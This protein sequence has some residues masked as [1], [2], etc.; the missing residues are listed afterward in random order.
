MIM[1]E[2]YGG[3]ALR[4]LVGV[5]LVFGII[6]GSI[7]LGAS[8]L[9]VDP[10]KYEGKY[11]LNT[12][13]FTF[14]EK[15]ALYYIQKYAIKESIS[16]ALVMGIIKHE[17]GG[18]FDPNTLGDKRIGYTGKDENMSIGYMQVWWTAAYDAGFRGT[19]KPIE[20]ELKKQYDWFYENCFDIFAKVTPTDEKFF[21]YID[22]ATKGLD[23]D[24]NVKY[25]ITYLRLRHDKIKDDIV[26]SDP[27]K[28]TISAYNAY[29]PTKRNEGTYVTPVLNN[30]IAYKGKYYSGVESGWPAEKPNEPRHPWEG[31]LDFEKGTDRAVISSTIQGL[32]FTTTLGLNWLYGDKHKYN[33]YPYGSKSYEA[34][35][36]FFA[37]LG[38]S[39]DQGII[40]FTKGTANYLS[41]LTSTS[42]GVKIDAYD[43]DNN[44]LVTSG[45]SGSNIN[46]RT[47]TRL[48]VESP[49]MAYATIHDTGNYWL[50]DDLTTD[51]LG[52]PSSHYGAAALAKSVVGAPYLGDG[53]TWGGKGWDPAKK[54]VSSTEIKD[55]YNYYDN[56][57][58]YKK[59]RW[60]QGLD[61]SGLV[62]WSYNKA[63]GATTYQYSNSED[64]LN[65]V[66]W[67]GA[68]KQY[69]YNFDI[70]VN[71]KEDLL[72]GDVLFFGDAATQSMYHVAMYVG[73]YPYTGTINGIP[74]DG[75]Y[76]VVNA[77]SPGLG[78]VPDKVE[79]LKSDPDF[80][81]YRRLSEPKVSMV[82][83]SHSPVNLIITDPDGIM[84]N[85]EIF[86]TPTSS[87]SEWDIDG[88]G[89]LDDMISFPERKIGDYL[90]EVVPEPG[91]LPTDTYT[92]DVTIGGETIVLAENVQISNIPTN[93]YI[94]RSTS[95]G[96]VLLL[97][98]T[99][100]VITNI[101]NTSDTNSAVITWETNEASDSLV[102]YGTSTGSYTLS[103]SGST[104]VLSHSV[105]LTGLTSDTLYYYV[106]NS[107]DGSQNHAQSTERIFRTQALA[108]TTPPVIESVTLYPVNATAGA[109]INVTVKAS[110]NVGVIEVKADSISLIY[111]NGEWNH[112]SITA[113]STIGS[114][115][116]TI[117]AND[118]AGNFAE[119]TAD[120]RVIA[121][122][123]GIGVGIS[124][125]TTTAPT[126]GTTIN[127]I[128]N[129]KS[130]QNFD[131]VVQVN[132]TTD[133][134]P[135]SYQMPLE[136]FNWN[137]QT[138]RVSSNVTVKLPL[139]L[140]I[141]PGQTAGKK[142]L[143]VRANSTM[144]I[145]KGFDT[146]IITIS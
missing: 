40:T 102:K 99:P 55:G 141:P 68:T 118:S 70:T 144:W 146:G 61:C 112:G 125:K 4:V 130:T 95:T 116:V 39:G 57:E 42:S 73:N 50:I 119:R 3:R 8:D 9:D 52:V 46:T 129:I 64:S 16:P 59:Y 33:V 91:A 72:P 124:P 62:F 105:S 107:T 138:V 36:N 37:W 115:T 113:P 114:Y 79:R 92:L 140:T 45:M 127:Y 18:A 87:Y 108:D 93:P 134:L 17:T 41:V 136:W 63:Y 145:T 103:E 21:A 71:N 88:D 132:V 1:S 51:A 44:F 117:R 19:A 122:K 96:I 47:F 111:S 32:E 76:D 67:E 15:A 126:T 66:H 26:Y 6:F 142:S 121:P 2:F 128:V 27:L 54:F 22:W 94:I 110:D 75:I 23:P 35:G 77:R 104:M 7:A 98:T 31:F 13:E 139:T 143:K 29:N 10:F 80:A 56:R 135:L 30:F 82:I 90:I 25:G 34:N 137:N 84:I 86:E 14:K 78:I 11:M 38:E 100:P 133:G 85:K 83:S 5:S 49:G 131:D 58:E 120:Y 69:K 43:A 60:G 106:V 53:I 65:P 74:Y 101:S 24:T 28:N 109:D 12:N 97:D 20:G 89:D 123:G 48:T 81:G